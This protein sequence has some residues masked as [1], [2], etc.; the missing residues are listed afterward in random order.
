MDIIQA[1]KNYVEKLIQPL[2]WLDYHRYNHTQEVYDRVVYLAEKEGIRGEDLEVLQLASIFH[3]SGYIVSYDNNEDFWAKIAENFLVT[4]G[5]SKTKIIIIKSLILATKHSYLDPK[6]ILEM[7][8][9]DADMDNQWKDDY[10]E[11]MEHLKTE[12]EISEWEKISEQEWILRCKNM[13][14]NTRFYTETQQTERDETKQKNLA[15]LE[16]QLH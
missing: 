16:S 4:H 9:K 6:N 2:E 12:R 11:K 15:S 1:S 14:K 10:V 7:I 5:Y 8:I 3:D 13:L